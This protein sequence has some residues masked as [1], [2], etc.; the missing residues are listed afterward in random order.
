MACQAIFTESPQMKSRKSMSS[1]LKQDHLGLKQG[2]TGPQRKDARS[3]GH[4]P[5]HLVT[6]YWF[7]FGL[8]ALSLITTVLMVRFDIKMG[9]GKES[10]ISLSDNGF[11]N[12][13]IPAFAT[14]VFAI[15]GVCAGITR[16]QPPH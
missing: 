12:V 8:A 6:R 10:I 5:Y 2:S 15:V 1:T 11:S 14:L 7:G 4:W 9:Y 13:I 3:N 16:R